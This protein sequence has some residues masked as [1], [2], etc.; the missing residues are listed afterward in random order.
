MDEKEGLPVV[1][2]PSATRWDAW[3]ADEGFPG[4]A[5]LRIAKKGAGVASVSYAQAVEIAIRH[6]WIDG[7]KAPL[8][9]RFWLQKFTPRRARSRWSERNRDLALR[10]IEEGRMTPAGLAEVEA[11]QLDGRWERAYAP[12]STATVPDDL[13]TA[14]DAMPKAAAA[15]DGLDAANRYAIL[16][17][18]QDAKRPETRARRIAAFVEM[19]ARGE[20]LHE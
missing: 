13:R 4:G 8:D 9:E 20:R 3:L 17:R 11:A 12:A 16:Y 2:F 10:L 18:V 5:W 19:L 6:G 14:L 7:Q 15:F 1:S